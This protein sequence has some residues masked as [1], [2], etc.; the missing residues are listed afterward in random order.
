MGGK[1]QQKDAKHLSG[2]Q[3]G[4]TRDRRGPARAGSLWL[5]HWPSCRVMISR[6]IALQTRARQPSRE[7]VAAQTE[8]W[9]PDTQDVGSAR[10][11][12]LLTRVLGLRVC[13]VGL[14]VASGPGCPTWASLTPQHL[15]LEFGT[16]AK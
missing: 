2:T 15:Q 3:R 16:G 14:H 9:Q 6:G 5:P 12:R 7:R 4:R 8:A 11:L 10:S 1:G 13:S